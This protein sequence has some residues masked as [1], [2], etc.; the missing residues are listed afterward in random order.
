MLILSNTLKQ[1]SAQ[2]INIIVSIVII[3]H[4]TKALW[5]SF[6]SYI[7]FTSFIGIVTSWGNKEYLLRE[8]SI[9]PSKINQLFYEVLN[10]RWPLLILSFVATFVMYDSNIAFYISIWIFSLFITQSFEVLI[11][12]KRIYITTILIEAFVFGILMVFL[13]K[14]NIKN[15]SQ[16]I[17]IYS[18]YQLLR[19]LV[20]TILFLK[21]IKKPLFQVKKQYFLHASLFFALGMV[22]FLQSRIDF[23][24]FSYF[25]TDEKTAIYQVINA[26]FILIHA[27]GTF[28][29][30]PFIKNIYR[31]NDLKI[32][33]LQN[34][35]IKIAPFIVLMALFILYL[36]CTFIYKFELPVVIYFIGFAIVYPPYFYAVK[37]FQLYKSNQQ[38]YVLKT[39]IIAIVINSF[40][41]LMLLNLNL[42]MLGVLLSSAIAHIYTAISYNRISLKLNSNLV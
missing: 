25:E 28:L 37:I 26:Y 36:L 15:I 14:F 40:L 41:S 29:I 10:A 39:G 7:I 17:S 6:T 21:D 32:E 30:F 23:I 16:L 31:F 18:L 11:N 5:G 19:A 13:L 42:E 4:Y 38:N 33:K 1:I 12:Y 27:A 34:L 35:I 3:N 8:F 22:G 2:A 24:I 9:T 20:F